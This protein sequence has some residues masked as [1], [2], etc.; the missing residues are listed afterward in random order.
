MEPYLID[1]LHV[2]DPCVLPL[3]NDK[4]HDKF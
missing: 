4:L 2:I 1:T 3:M